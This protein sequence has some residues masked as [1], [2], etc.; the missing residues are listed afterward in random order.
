MYVIGWERTVKSS[1]REGR[2]SEVETRK[3]VTFERVNWDEMVEMGWEVIE[4]A[5]GR[6]GRTVKA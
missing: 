5:T 3:E 1:F 6:K 2:A 4:D